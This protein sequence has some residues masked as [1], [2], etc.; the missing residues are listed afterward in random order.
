MRLTDEGLVVEDR[1]EGTGT[2][3]VDRLWHFAP[4]LERAGASAVTGGGIVATATSTTSTGSASDG[5]WETY[6]HSS[7]YGEVTSAP[8]LRVRSVVALPC[9]LTTTWSVAPCAA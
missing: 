6:P 3:T 5:V 7:V 4:A 8:L 9:T 1:L 2:V